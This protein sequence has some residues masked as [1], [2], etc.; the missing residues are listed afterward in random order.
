MGLLN[1]ALGSLPGHVDWRRDTLDPLLESVRAFADPALV[2]FADVGG[3]TVGFL[4]GLPNLNQVLIHANGLRWP[5]N[6]WWTALRLRRP[7][8]ELTVKS[9]VVDPK[10]WKRGVAALLFGEFLER[11]RARGYRWAD[12]SITG[13]DNP[14]TVRLATRI[15]GR[16]YKRWQVYKRAVSSV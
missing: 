6:R 13:A 15:G 4:P 7:F 12:L 8:T 10:Y 14:N 11:A 16:E 1:R 9:V 2:L 5:W 3:E